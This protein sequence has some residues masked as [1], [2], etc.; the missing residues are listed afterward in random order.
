MDLVLTVLNVTRTTCAEPSLFL[1]PSFLHLSFLPPFLPFLQYYLF[2]R[3]FKF[4]E[5]WGELM[6]RDFPNTSFPLGQPPPSFPNRVVYW[7]QWLNLHGHI[8]NL[9]SPWFTLWHCTFYG[10]GQI[11]KDMYPSLW[12]GRVLSW[13]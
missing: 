1:L 4:T 2:K 3:T 12:Y 11:L 9:Q 8:H 5:N 6:Y 7:L 10:L 13:L